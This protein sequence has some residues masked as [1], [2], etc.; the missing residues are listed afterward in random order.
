M[1]RERE[2]R[3]RSFP[4]SIKWL[5]QDTTYDSKSD[6]KRLNKKKRLKML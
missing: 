2:N 3:V 1:K 6:G 5:L 4:I